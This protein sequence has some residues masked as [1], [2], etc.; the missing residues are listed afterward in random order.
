VIGLIKELGGPTI[1]GNYDFCVGKGYDSYRSAYEDETGTI[2]DQLSIVC[3][4]THTTPE[5]K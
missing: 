4:S 2:L 5:N 1:M 3:K